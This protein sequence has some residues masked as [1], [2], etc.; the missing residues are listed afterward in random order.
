MLTLSCKPE[1]G[2]GHPWFYCAKF[3]HIKYDAQCSWVGEECSPLAS[4]V[5]LEMKF[6][7]NA[8]FFRMQEQVSNWNKVWGK[9]YLKKIGEKNHT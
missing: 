8:V 4:C 3:W 2:K 7:N 5:I 9:K 6:F 1:G